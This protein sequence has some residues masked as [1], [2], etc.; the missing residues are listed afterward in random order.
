MEEFAEFMRSNWGWILSFAS[1]IGGLSTY[2]YGHLKALQAGVQALL[3]AQMISDYN[4]YR[5]KGYAPV[6]AR[7]SFENCWISYERLGKNGVMS[8]IHANFFALPTNPPEKGADK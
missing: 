7:E 8:N 2:V 1:V 5:A 6:Y 4:H 3:R